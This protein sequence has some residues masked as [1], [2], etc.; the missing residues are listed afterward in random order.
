MLELKLIPKFPHE[1]IA[2]DEVGRGPLSGPVVIGAVRILIEDAQGLKNLLKFLKPKGVTDSKKL[3]PEKRLTILKK[4][5]VLDL[6]Y[7]KK[8]EVELKGV[9]VSYTTWDMDHEVIDQ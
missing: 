5:G 6:S 8:N 9:K 1:I 2:T 4:L 3:T 7:R